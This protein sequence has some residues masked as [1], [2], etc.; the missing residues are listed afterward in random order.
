MLP[1]VHVFSTGHMHVHCGDQFLPALEGAMQAPTSKFRIALYSVE[2]NTDAQS[3]VSVASVI[4]MAKLM[5]TFASLQTVYAQ[6]GT[7]S[8]HVAYEVGKTQYVMQP[9]DRMVVLTEDESLATVL[10]SAATCI[11]LRRRAA[12]VFMQTQHERYDGPA[13]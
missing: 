6:D 12:Q 8:T 4:Q 9:R 7:S 11:N 13:V 2:E 3:L 5:A 1:K 10:S